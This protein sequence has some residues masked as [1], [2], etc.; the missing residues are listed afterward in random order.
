MAMQKLAVRQREHP[1]FYVMVRVNH[2]EHGVAHVPHLVAAG[3]IHQIEFY[4]LP[5]R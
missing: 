1:V 2:G 5:I 4:R 3:G